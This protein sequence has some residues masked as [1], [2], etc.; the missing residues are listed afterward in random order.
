MTS[1]ASVYKLGHVIASSLE[2]PRVPLDWALVDILAPQ[3]KMQNSVMDNTSNR[4]KIPITTFA[5]HVPPVGTPVLSVT[6]S[7][8]LKHGTVIGSPIIVKWAR[9]V[10][11]QE[12]WIVGMEAGK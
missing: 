4:T 11:F 3:L 5:S 7:S 12:L 1:S 9:Q 8:G 6:G 2:G 10:C